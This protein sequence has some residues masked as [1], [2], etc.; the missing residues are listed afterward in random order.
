[1]KPKQLL[2][3]ILIVAAGLCG[4]LIAQQGDNTALSLAWHEVSTAVFARGYVLTAGIDIDQDGRGEILTYD[5]AQRPEVRG[6]GDGP[7]V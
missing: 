1:M 7:A 3:A 4:Q 6:I 5:G 2:P